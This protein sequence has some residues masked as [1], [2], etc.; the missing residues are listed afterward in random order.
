MHPPAVSVTPRPRVPRV[1]VR[2]AVGGRAGDSRA[3]DDVVEHRVVVGHGL[4]DVAVREPAGLDSGG[5][6]E[7]ATWC[8]TRTWRPGRSVAFGIS[9]A[10]QEMSPTTN[11]NTG[12]TTHP[13]HQS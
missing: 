4:V 3:T 13:N 9:K 11:T 5:A 7:G 6:L 1:A 12:S 2:E 10:G 8:R